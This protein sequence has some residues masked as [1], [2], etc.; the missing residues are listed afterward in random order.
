MGG[1]EQGT[2]RSSLPLPVG[3][4]SLREKKNPLHSSKKK[5]NWGGER[6][7][8]Q[9]RGSQFSFFSCALPH[10]HISIQ[11]Q[12]LHGRVN[13]VSSN[14]VMPQYSQHKGYHTDGLEQIPHL[15]IKRWHKIQPHYTVQSKTPLTRRQY[16][17]YLYWFVLWTVCHR[18]NVALQS[19]GKWYLYGTIP[20]LVSLTPDALES[21]TQ[22][23]STCQQQIDQEFIRL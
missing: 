23:F 22:W 8:S 5:K 7:R 20:E 2:Q 13:R 6:E 17:D 1:R 9:D 4:G 18:P 19:Q 15:M 11:C 21:S 12:D 10:A 3:S 16:G 14:L